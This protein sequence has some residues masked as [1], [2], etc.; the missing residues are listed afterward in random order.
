MLNAVVK[1][2][3]PLYLFCHYEVIKRESKDLIKFHIITLCM[4]MCLLLLMIWVCL[5]VM[6]EIE[7]NA[8][9]KWKHKNNIKVFTLVH[10]YRKGD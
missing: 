6:R 3:Y 10:G 5:F 9:N 8:D 7:E 4:T 2:S 1:D